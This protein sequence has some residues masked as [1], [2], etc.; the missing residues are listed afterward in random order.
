MKGKSLIYPLLLIFLSACSDFWGEETGTEFLDIPI[1]Q[2]SQVAYIPI[3]PV[4]KDVVKPVDVEAGF[5]ELIYVVD[6]A[7]EEL[8]V[9][10]QAGRRITSRTVPGIKSVKQD[11]EL[12]LLAIGTFDT[13][14][15]GV[16]YSLS[17]IYKF[18]P[19]YDAYNLASLELDKRLVHPFYLR[20]TFSAGDTAKFTDIA[21]MGDGRYYISRTGNNNNINQ[22]GGPDDAVLIFSPD[23]EFITPV[24][25][26][27]ATGFFRDYFKQPQSITTQINAPQRI[28]NNPGLSFIVCMADE[29]Q[30]LQVKEIEVLSDEN[31][32]SYRFVPSSPDPSKADDYLY[33]P[34]KF[35]N[36][37]DVKWAG[38][39]TYFFVL[40]E[41]KDS[42]YIFNNLK[43]EGVDP[44]PAAEDSRLI[45]VSFGGMGT[46]ITQFNSP[47]ALS[48]LDE[49]LYVADAG[50]SRV[51]RFKLTTDI[52]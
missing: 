18:K 37:I 45:N 2:R 48:F 34:N 21:V 29:T 8:I 12:N 11:R 22:F 33:R 25:V 5:D 52:E 36:P 6:E 35:I 31:G 28:D 38:T 27:T 46:G 41:A 10:D 51:L 14:I 50:N 42:V 32:I 30:P 13:V 39:N 17:A 4:I 47:R 49:I 26:S 3:Q 24:F 1:E 23:L 40:D 16:Q 7:T 43:L 19:N 9:F 20:N 44:P 15:S